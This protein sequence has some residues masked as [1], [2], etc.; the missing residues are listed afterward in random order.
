LPKDN[1]NI[2]LPFTGPIES[3]EPLGFAAGEMI[4]CDDCLRANPPTRLN[5]IYCAATLP[6]TEWSVRLRKPS[7]RR[8]EKHEP[9]Y[10]SIILPR[11][12]IDTVPKALE[13]CASLLKLSVEQLEQIL[14]KRVPLPVARTA[15]EEEAQLVEERLLDLGFHVITLTDEQLGFTDTCVSKIRAM[16]F[17]ENSVM[18]Q[19]SQTG[20]PVE[21]AWS[22][23]LLIMPG[24]LLTRKVE[25]KESRSRKAENEIIDSSQFF[26][27]EA[28]IDFYSANNLRT[29]RVSSN[30]FDFS[31]LGA[32]KALVANENIATLERLIV[33]KSPNAF[34]DDSY[35][36]LRQTLDPVWGVEQ[37]TE[38][39][40][41]Q[42]VRPGK[43]SLGATT[44]N[45]N[46]S[47][48]TRYSRLRFYFRVNPG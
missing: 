16:Q 39:K 27:D 31:C 45:S 38:S 12:Q 5:C 44:V 6:L 29:W 21:I 7:M 18:V 42:R 19:T 34:R 43:F 13:E 9:G 11:D 8:P 32:Q 3:S 10:N 30:S 47:Q 2:R 36:S 20:D 48:F 46:E 33:E 1:E 24:R 41:W 35:H 28:V 23:L 40:G 25:V 4:R 37:A 22:D 26:I 14:S 15:S 17:Q